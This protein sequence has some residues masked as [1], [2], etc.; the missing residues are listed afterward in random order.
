MKNKRKILESGKTLLIFALIISAVFLLS[1]AIFYE[2]GS[3]LSNIKE[4]FVGNTEILPE[5][6]EAA[7]GLPHASPA[8]ILIS[9]GKSF[10]HAEKYDK[11]EKE[12]L[13]SMF[14]ASLGE[15][16]GSAGTPVKI[17]ET[18]WQMAL[19]DSGIF[20][21]Y[22]Y[23]QSLTGIASWLG[24]EIANPLTSVSSRRIYL[25]ASAQKLILY[26]IDSSDG[27]FYRCETA[28]NS[29]AITPKFSEYVMGTACFAFEK[30]EL[31]SFDPYFI[32][33]GKS[34]SLSAV[35]AVNPLRGDEYNDEFLATFGL[36]SKVSYDYSENDGSVVFVD[37]SKTLRIYKN[38]SLSFS[39]TGEGIPVSVSGET[40]NMNDCISK[41]DKI[42]QS[43]L[44]RFCGEANIV[45]SALSG[46]A[47]ASCTVSFSYS[48]DGV[49][50]ELNS[51]AYA[52]SFEF[53]DGRITS[54]ELVFRQYVLIDQ[55]L[56]PLPEKQAI[57]VSSVQGGEPVLVYTDNSGG[58]DARWILL[59]E[60]QE[61]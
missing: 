31:S 41:A 13:Y 60:A 49:P 39:S 42:V 16:L 40:I 27:L 10:H 28:L 43:T 50:V 56:L 26:Y 54:V 38:G 52:A 48:V 35:S 22:I 61:K 46:K 51:G 23:P 37:G 19:S 47:P 11:S 59:N 24:T 9:T 18:D 53:T 17:S 20:F 32:V 6:D 58:I 44:G 14:S 57:A 21:D 29:A 30:S 33:S 12:K 5:G 25:S 3:V 34:I 15:A 2:P 4:L 8:Y 45:L 7:I 1:K 36:N 55:D